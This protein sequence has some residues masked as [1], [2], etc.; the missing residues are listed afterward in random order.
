MIAFVGDVDT[1]ELEAL[2]LL[3]YSYVNENGGV[4]VLP[5]PVVHNH[6]LCFDDVE[7]EVV[8]LAPHSQ[9]SDLH[10]IE[11]LI[12]VGDQ[13]YLCC[14]VSK[15]NDGVGVVPGHAVMSEHG[16][17]E[18]TEHI[19]LRG[20]RVEDQRD[21]CVVTYPYHQGRPVRK[22]RIQLQREVFSLGP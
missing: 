15:P 19:H 18:G 5:F 10:P 14:V 12:V 17:Q 21:G 9:V 22:S 3:H 6:L 4:L 7:E 8:I 1:K 16:V 11:C 13:A 2:N 20:L